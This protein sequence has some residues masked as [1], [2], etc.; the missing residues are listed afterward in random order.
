MGAFFVIVGCA[1]TSTCATSRL[2]LLPG[3][4][5]GDVIEATK[6]GGSFR[7]TVSERFQAK[8]RFRVAGDLGFAV[9]VLF[10]PRLRRLQPV[11]DSVASLPQEYRLD[12]PPAQDRTD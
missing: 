9:P 11:A 1:S 8:A 12:R 5:D 4:G 2:F 3:D 10:I 6:F 7:A